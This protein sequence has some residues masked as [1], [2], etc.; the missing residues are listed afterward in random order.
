MSSLDANVHTV[1]IT[2]I[3]SI[4]GPSLINAL[5]G[6]ANPRLKIVGVDMNPNSIGFKFVD[7][8]GTVPHGSSSDYLDVLLKI[9]KKEEVELIIPG[10]DEEVF[11]L[12]KGIDKLN[13]LGVKLMA[14]SSYAVEASLNKGKL[15]SL[16][17][18]HNVPVP[19]FFLPQSITDL[20]NVME[21]LGYPRNEV[22]IKP[23]SGRGGRG[24]WIVTDKYNGQDL[25]MKSR[26]LQRLP[27]SVLRTLLSAKDQLPPLIVMQ[28]LPG[29]DF[30]V[31]ILCYKGKMI[32]CVP[33][34]RLVPE[35]GP[36]QVG[37]IVH[38]V[39]IDKI[40]QS[41][42]EKMDYSYVINI[43]V[44]YPDPEGMSTPLPY[45]INPRLS[46]PIAGSAAAGINLLNLSVKMAL[47]YKIPT[48]LTY[49]SLIMR[50][51]WAEQY[52]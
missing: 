14:S 38:D 32:Y 29:P 23:L 43:E 39:K 16:L 27:Y 6:D 51:Y 25:I 17:K 44:A 22:V 45:E 30:N 28:Y 5:R 8:S 35:A 13:S 46:G 47:G 20:D 33:M 36:V 52:V 11:A 49:K 21:K 19:D 12:T 7:T 26:P 2:S 34:E 1:L 42:I 18:E 4:S 40:C 15:L 37:R 3:G 31:D 9:C 10:S 24:F 41:I 48:D 50:R